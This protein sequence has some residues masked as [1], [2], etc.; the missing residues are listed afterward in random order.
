MSIR[1]GNATSKRRATYGPKRVDKNNC[2]HRG[3][4]HRGSDWLS[5]RTL[6]GES[7]VG[8]SS[9]N[10]YCSS[11]GFGLAESGEIAHDY[12]SFV[13]LFATKHSHAWWTLALAQSCAGYMSRHR[14]DDGVA[15][16]SVR[17]GVL[18]QR[19]HGSAVME[20]V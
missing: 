20:D 19:R 1:R 6:Y 12:A 9:S 14:R 15:R 4:D 18:V 10:L 3:S 11:V 8:S 7:C 13:V 16:R 17:C 2:H 5:C